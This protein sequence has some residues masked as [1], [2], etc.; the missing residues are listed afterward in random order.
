MIP[1]STRASAHVWPALVPT[2]SFYCALF[3]VAVKFEGGKTDDETVPLVLPKAKAPISQQE[4]EPGVEHVPD[5][6]L[7]VPR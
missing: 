1:I 6:G 4:D 2:L 3:T 7:A 5:E